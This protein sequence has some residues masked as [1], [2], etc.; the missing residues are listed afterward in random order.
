MRTCWPTASSRPICGEEIHFPGELEDR[1]ER[2]NR[3]AGLALPVQTIAD[4]EQL[5]RD[6]GVELELA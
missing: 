3:L 6:T 5:A 1:S 4:L 2:R